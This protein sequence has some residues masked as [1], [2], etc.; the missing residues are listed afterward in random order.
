M[1]TFNCGGTLGDAFIA[2]CYLYGVSAQEKI[3]I[4]HWNP[5]SYWDK[6]IVEIYSLLPNAEVVF[7]PKED[8]SGRQ[9]W[10]QMVEKSVGGF[11]PFPEFE[12]PSY[13]GLP[14]KYIILAPRSGKP[15]EP[16]RVMKEKEV[17]RQIAE[18]N[19]PVVML[20]DGVEADGVVDLRGKTTI[21]EALFII[22]KAQK[23]IGFQGLLSYMAL[24]QKIPS[25]V[26]TQSEREYLAFRRRLMRKW[27]PYCL[28]ILLRDGS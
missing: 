16:T 19:L 7:I 10:T 23:F 13:D 1:K 15:T 14:S 6:K 26:Y 5:H 28:D 4:R 21:K 9:A 18:H 12:L 24:S 20:G 8:K 3:K 11:T 27:M 2:V 22:S 25:V 17:R